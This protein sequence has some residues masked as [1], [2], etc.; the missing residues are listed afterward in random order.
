MWGVEGRDRLRGEFVYLTILP[1]EYM[2]FVP[3]TLV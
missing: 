3:F 1:M 2:E